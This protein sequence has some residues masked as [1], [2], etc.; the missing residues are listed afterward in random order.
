MSSDAER[1][2]AQA[3]EVKQKIE[4]AII[5]VRLECGW[6]G[7]RYVHFDSCNCDWEEDYM[8]DSRER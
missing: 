7:D 5:P 8:R 3:I 4:E 6:Y 1:I 2:L